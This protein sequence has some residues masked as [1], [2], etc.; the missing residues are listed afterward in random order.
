MAAVRQTFHKQQNIYM[1]SIF[2]EAFGGW[3]PANVT[4]TGTAICW[5]TDLSLPTDA[6]VYFS[7]H[8]VWQ[9]LIRRFRKALRIDDFVETM[10]PQQRAGRGG[11]DPPYS[12]FVFGVDVFGI[13]HHDFISQ[14]H[15]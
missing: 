4:S 1:Y 13:A 8:W 5:L 15:A 12:P 6:V 7:K 9:H 11:S 3:H 2:L 10:H 14:P